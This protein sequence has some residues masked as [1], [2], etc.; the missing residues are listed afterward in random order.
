MKSEAKGMPLTSTTPEDA[1]HMPAGAPRPTP[2]TTLRV[3]AEQELTA[4]ERAACDVLWWRAFAAASEA[5]RSVRP[6]PREAR[7]LLFDDGGAL[8]AAAS[9]TPCLVAIAGESVRVA[10]LGGVAVPEER[11]GRGYGSRVVAAFAR[12]AAAA[13]YAWAARACEPR[14]RAFYERLGWRVLAGPLTVREAE[15]QRPPLGFVMALPLT[16]EAAADLPTWL[17]API[18]LGPGEW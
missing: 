4:D 11:R 9:L 10:G 6:P 17:S 3:R 16:P 7:L 18:I 1:R 2:S 15:R 5:E 14:R 8:L 12:H 13:G